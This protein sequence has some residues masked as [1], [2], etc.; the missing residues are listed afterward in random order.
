MVA[1]DTVI[2]Y[3]LTIF[4]FCRKTEE[5]EKMLGRLS[6]FILSACAF[7]FSAF[8]AYTENDLIEIMLK[9]APEIKSLELRRSAEREAMKALAQSRVEKC[10]QAIFERV[11][12]DGNR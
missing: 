6:L 2:C 10:G 11:V 5:E 9:E 4:A 12:A 8:A 1:N 3:S 7:C